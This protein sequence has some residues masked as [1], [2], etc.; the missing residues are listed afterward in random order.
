MTVAN[1]AP[2]AIAPGNGGA[3]SLAVPVPFL[4][5]AEIKVFLLSDLGIE[6]QIYEGAGYTVV[7]AKISGASPIAY[8]GTVTT[9][10]NLA[11]T[12]RLIVFVDPANEQTTDYDSRP[13]L[14]SEYERG[15]DLAAKRDAALRELI[16]RSVR[17]PLNHTGPQSVIS[18]EPG[19]VLGWSALGSIINLAAVAVGEFLFG[20]IGEQ[21]ALTGSEAEALEVLN[22]TYIQDYGS[23]SIALRKFRTTYVDPSNW[24]SVL[25]AAADSEEPTIR[26]HA[27]SRTDFQDQW[28]IAGDGQ[29]WVGDG[30]DNTSYLYRTVD[31]DEPAIFVTGERCGMRHIGLRGTH[32]STP[33]DSNNVGILVQRPDGDPTDCDF[34]FRNGYISKFYYGVHGLGRGIT[35][36][37][38]LIS[39]VRYGVNFDW[40]AD[41]TY[42][43]DRFVGDSDTNGF[44]RQ[45]VSRCE[46]HSIAVA[47]VRNRGWNAENIHLVIDGN[48]SNFGKGI[49]QGFLGDGSVIQNNVIQNANF[50]AYVLDGGTNWIMRNNSM[51]VDRTV[52]G[53][54]EPDHFM[55]M[56][57]THTGFLINGFAARGTK[58]SDG[59]LAASGIDM[60][61][62]DFV[63]ILRN[64]DLSAIGTDTL[65]ISDAVTI[66]GTGAATDILIDGLTLRN[67]SAARS[68]IRMDTALS[69]CKHR[70][71]VSLGAATPLT[72]GAGTFT[73]V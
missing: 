27:D 1:L 43:K 3:T 35:V 44:R 55:E 29:K 9:I 19:K 67:A 36:T 25:Q 69:T 42:E 47:A 57:G 16:K 54:P 17:L 48:K 64:I 15:F 6:S 40:P 51:H 53:M 21:L 31:V 2:I 73:A 13:F 45:I 71:I 10:A 61:D 49:F 18:P 7:K 70:G 34:E 41:G 59:I 4:T 66:V 56:T 30:M 62:G 24:S 39:A 50:V 63:G 46:F 32:A 72:S 68:I 38:S 37:D 33:T 28:A 11:S 60:R 65:A 58:S 52:G 12:W 5:N 20:T 8:S 14:P 26:L 22:L 23:H